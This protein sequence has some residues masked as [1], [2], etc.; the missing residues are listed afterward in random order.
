MDKGKQP[1]EESFQRKRNRV[2]SVESD[3]SVP[4]EGFMVD[5]RHASSEEEFFRIKPDADP[6]GQL[7][8]VADHCRQLILRL[9]L[10]I[11]WLNECLSKA[12]WKELRQRSQGLPSL[13]GTLVRFY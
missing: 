6:T 11:Q 3:E 7:A 4:G 5:A 10:P 2:V 9:R 12:D 8:D 13:Y 1:A